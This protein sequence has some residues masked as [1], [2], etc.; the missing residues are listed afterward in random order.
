M[1]NIMFLMI[2]VF[3]IGLIIISVF[4]K[5]INPVARFGEYV[6]KI[7]A[8]ILIV[9]TFIC[10]IFIY[11]KT[12]HTIVADQRSSMQS[13]EQFANIH[14]IP[15][16]YITETIKVENPAK[17]FDLQLKNMEESLSSWPEIYVEKDPN[18]T[19]MEIVVYESP[20]L[21]NQIDISEDFPE[22][23]ITVEN[24]KLIFS[25]KKVG[26]VTRNF[27]E[28]I[29]DQF[30]AQFIPNYQYTENMFTEYESGSINIHILTP[31]YVQVTNNDGMLFIE[32]MNE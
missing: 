2:P 25:D 17:Q 31:K 6:I 27:Y 29:H 28:M 4:I 12:Q 19:D 32:Y 3:V 21:F 16:E 30:T 5:Y 26:K 8:G 11:P 10:F 18:R 14:M 23:E 9:V 24:D 13:L 7:Y 22:T 20:H 1:T 15:D